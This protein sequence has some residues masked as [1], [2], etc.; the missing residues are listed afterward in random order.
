MVKSMSKKELKRPQSPA[1]ISSERDKISSRV[2]NLIGSTFASEQFPTKEEFISSLLESKILTKRAPTKEEKEKGYLCFHGNLHIDNRVV[3]NLDWSDI[4]VDSATVIDG[5]I[6]KYAYLPR[7]RLGV[8]SNLDTVNAV[9]FVEHNAYGAEFGR[10]EIVV[11]G[12]FRIPDREILPDFSRVK[13]DRVLCYAKEVRLSDLPYSKEGIFGVSMEN[14][15]VDVP[16]PAQMAKEKKLG[17]QL[18]KALEPGLLQRWFG[19]LLRDVK[20]NR[21]GSGQSR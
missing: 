17:K 6:S 16:N 20:K 1:E 19:N 9:E 4:V 8:K 13:A 14:L 2:N 21:Q 5:K 10:Q 7:T 12:N 11:K 3:S 15:K 18:C